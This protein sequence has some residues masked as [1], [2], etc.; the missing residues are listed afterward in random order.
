MLRSLAKIFGLT[1]LVLIG[2]AGIYAYYARSPQEKQIR[3]LQ[4]EKKQLEQIVQRLGEERRL[5]EL[6]VTEQK[7][8][9]G[10]LNTTVLFVE[11]AKNGGAL[12]PKSFVLQ[13]EKIHIDAMVIKFDGQYVQ[14]NDPLRGHSIALFTKI[15]G[16]RQTP[17][18][19]FDIDAP[20]RIPDIYRGADPKVSAFEQKLWQDFWR[21]AQ[22][23]SYR[24]EMGVRVADGQ[25]TWGPL[26]PDM[27]YTLSIE[28]N[29]GINRSSEPLRGIYR[30]ALKMR[31]N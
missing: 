16:D 19:G 17:A 24:A 6:L 2:S 5:A 25:G 22:D 20:G 30:E 28:S 23:K 10:V 18:E 12:P 8:V 31:S 7:T 4:E 15:Y 26:E 1:V 13:G 3:Q 9:D 21:L 29:G 11:Y 27:L 14:Q